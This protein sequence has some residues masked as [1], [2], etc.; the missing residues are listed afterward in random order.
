MKQF[1]DGQILN[2]VR[3]AGA[4]YNGFKNL[5]LKQQLKTEITQ[6][7]QNALNSADNKTRE[8]LFDIPVYGQTPS[9]QGTAGSPTVARQNPPPVGNSQNAGSQNNING[10]T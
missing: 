9:N 4:V 10:F 6:G 5:N 8:K 1:S 7:I 3:T 2:G